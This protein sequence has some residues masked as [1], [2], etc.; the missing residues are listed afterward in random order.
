MVTACG[1][2]MSNDWRAGAPGFTAATTAAHT[3]PSGI[4]RK[5]WSPPTTGLNAGKAASARINPVPPKAARSTTS[6]G[7]RISQSKPLAS[8]SRSVSAFVR[9]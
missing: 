5:V 2:G 1:P 6:D 8:T 7:R 9:A 3:S 4:G